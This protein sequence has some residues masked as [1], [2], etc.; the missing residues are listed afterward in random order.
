MQ[1]HRSACNT[2]RIRK[3]GYLTSSAVLLMML[4][5]SFVDS[6]S[7][8]ASRLSPLYASSPSTTDMG[9]GNT[10]DE[11]TLYDI[12][13][14]S[15]TD[16]QQQL[17]QNYRNLVRQ[18]HPDAVPQE[19]DKEQ[20]AIQ[21]AEIAAAWN[22]LSNPKERLRYDRTMK[23]KEFTNN[24]EDILE[25]GFRAAFETAYQTA[26]G[27]KSV[28]AQ[29]DQVRGKTGQKLE[30]ARKIAEYTSK[31][32]SLQQRAKRESTRQTELQQR[33]AN[34]QRHEYLQQVQQQFISGKQQQQ[35]QM[36]ST[37][38][39]QVVK[40]FQNYDSLPSQTNNS[41]YG[42]GNNSNGNAGINFAESNQAVEKTIDRLNE[43]EEDYRQMT[44]DFQKTQKSLT[45][46]Q[47]KIDIAMME[48]ERA[49]KK[50][51][52][53]QAQFEQVQRARQETEQAYGEV[54]QTERI[55]YSNMEKLEST[56]VKQQDRTR[57]TLKRTEDLYIWKEN[58]YLKE[59]SKKSANLSQKLLDKAQELQIKAD[60]L[61]REM[62]SI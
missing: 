30:M 6:F 13:Q 45:Q 21:F 54:L 12:L 49:Y 29:F 46:A 48:E 3:T 17:R 50:L 61:K 35:Q 9:D 7:Y 16:S 52:E 4:L 34:R 43:M 55:A 27:I 51:Q 18:T 25:G 37:M 57:E 31:S 33:L 53:A 5:L 36:T 59:E 28:G 20:A 11:R 24:V 23:A 32:R 42:F 38:A 10:S 19:S 44:L 22:I 1:V 62:D 60:E 58:A 47:R 8:S 15:P 40:T 14:A 41:V 2:A 39:S 26:G 56:L